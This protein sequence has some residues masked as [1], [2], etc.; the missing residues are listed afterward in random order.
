MLSC[1]YRCQISHRRL[2]PKKHAFNYTIFY[3]WLD[4]DSLEQWNQKVG[5]LKYNRRGVYSVRDEDFFK[6]YT[7]GSIKERVSQWLVE[8]GVDLKD[9]NKIFL[10]TFPRVLGY[11]FNPVSFYV[12]Y[13]KEGE[14]KFCVA[15][16]TNTFLER[17]PYLI[18]Q[19]DA[20]GR[21]VSRQPKHF[22][23]SPFSDLQVDFI[24]KIGEIRERL[25]IQIN[26]AEGEKVMLLS[27][28]Q[29]EQMKLT[30]LRLFI[31]LFCYPLMTI[32]VILRIHWQAFKLY[33]KGL[34]VFAKKNSPH[35]QTKLYNPYSSERL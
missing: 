21:L 27:H 29:G 8:N 7:Q 18:D 24:F 4:L 9:V 22:Y 14:R 19:Q 16:V 23:V 10:L 5:L 31:Y 33:L 35:L 32:N 26:H 20:R 13:D 17:K 6:G 1:L 11:L 15:E 28:L 3:L 34:K 12:G 30:N 25:N 2:H